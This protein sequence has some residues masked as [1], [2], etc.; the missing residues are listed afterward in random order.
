MKIRVRSVA[1]IVVGVVFLTL[2]VS[3]F[4]NFIIV[5]IV[6]T[7]DQ[8]SK[9]LLNTLN[10]LQLK[11]NN[12]AELI[13]FLDQREDDVLD[14]AIVQLKEY[15]MRSDETLSSLNALMESL[16]GVTFGRHRLDLEESR[17]LLADL[18]AYNRYLGLLNRERVDVSVLMSTLRGILPLQEAALAKLT[19]VQ[20]RLSNTM[21]N[22]LAWIINGLIALLI[23]QIVIIIAALIYT[24]NQ[25]PRL[26]ER[27]RALVYAQ[28]STSRQSS[29]TRFQ[30]LNEIYRYIDELEDERNFLLELRESL[31]RVYGVD[32]VMDALFEFL[33]RRFHVF[34]LGAAFV[35]YSKQQIIAEYGV[36]E[37]GE[38][39]LGPGFTQTFNETSISELLSAPAVRVDVDIQ[40]SLDQRPNSKSLRLIVAEGIRSNVTMPLKVGDFVF[41]FLFVSS[42]QANYFTSQHLESLQEVLSEVTSILH[43]AFFT[44]VIFSKIVVNFANLVEQRDED[45]GQHLTRM[46]EYSRLIASALQK[47]LDPNYAIDARFVL[48]LQRSAATHDLGKVSVPDDVLKKPGP[49]SKAEWAIM[50]QH[51]ESGAKIFQDFR[52]GLRNFDQTL[53]KMAEDIALYHHEK[54]DG[55]GYPMG[56]K[57]QAIPLA[58]RI[59][60]VA[61][62]FDALSSRRAYKEAMSLDES[63]EALRALKGTHL[64]PHLVDVFLNLETQIRVLHSKDA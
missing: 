18:I 14:F 20:Y 10:T 39:K 54:F 53:F 26:T 51:P 7:Y 57:G 2:I 31:A 43:R 61:D 45:T 36:I 56:L 13:Q 34:R 3:L 8:Q 55:S 15:Q 23:T 35:D 60:A 58:A 50:R 46:V 42:N 41:G 62:V 37:S 24:L 22:D 6:D 28:T 17:L 9:Q 32:D 64:D 1:K 59:V 38:V 4:T 29:M 47:D 30:E 33:N 25:A 12:S 27:L 49:L 40:A 5:P 11:T 44:K 63:F 19:V 52:E 48:E 16:S 21:L